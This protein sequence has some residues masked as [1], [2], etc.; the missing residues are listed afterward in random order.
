MKQMAAAGAGRLLTGCLR[1]RQTQRS[2]WAGCVG[3]LALLQT[4]PGQGVLTTNRTTAPAPLFGRLEEDANSA[5]GFSSSTAEAPFA[6]NPAGASVRMSVLAPAFYL[7]LI[8]LVLTVVM[9]G[10]QN[11]R[12]AR[13]CLLAAGACA[14]LGAILVLFLEAAGFR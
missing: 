2:L 6:G 12:A 8:C 5:P 1:V 10:R 14:V 13:V 3:W 11:R 9:M 7:I 4:G